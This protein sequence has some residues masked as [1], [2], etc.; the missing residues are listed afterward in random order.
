MQKVLAILLKKNT[1]IDCSQKIS[2]YALWN[3]LT[4]KMALMIIEKFLV[5]W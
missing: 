1:I 4:I 5:R 2:L 3:I